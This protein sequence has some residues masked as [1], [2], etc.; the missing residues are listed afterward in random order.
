M[1]PQ[2][3]TKQ[4]Q[5]Q[6]LIDN[7]LGY[8][9]TWIADIGLKAGMFNA[10]AEAG[11]T[12][13]ASDA[14]ASKLKLAPGYV[15]VWCRAAYAFELLDW[16]ETSGYRLAPHM[17][18][19]LL[20]AADP[21]FLG[22]RI[23]FAAALYEDFRAFPEYLRSGEVWPRSAHDPW[24]LEALKNMTKP[25]SRVITEAVL[26]QL[27]RTLVHLE[28][29]GV[30]LDIGA[31]A[32]F[33]L[34][35]LATC[36]PKARVVGLEYDMPS[37][38]LAR[39][40]V[41]EAGLSDRIEVRHGDANLLSDD[42]AYDLVMMNVTLH[43]TGGPDE[44]RNVLDR[45]FRALKP[46]GTVVVSE[47]PHPDSATAYRDEPVYRMLAGVQLHEALVGC[48]SITQGELRK[49]LEGA[50]FAGVRVAEQPLPTRIMMIA[51]KQT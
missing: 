44:Y 19:L 21:R 32:G 15:A 27:P 26:P 16:D 30:I 47:L 10:I 13:I 3:L 14:L 46:N 35:H 34:I 25:D 9:A 43:E 33:A 8:Q 42:N 5:W 36:F 31:G 37:V 6:R 28:R 20:D 41:E 38:D 29:G 7:V 2:E 18:S 24:L 40:A 49:L 12:G 48:G 17:N 50:G 22:G 51:E 23:Q 39:R 4:A 1:P 11:P 45:V